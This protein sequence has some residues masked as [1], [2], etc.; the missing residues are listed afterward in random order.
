[1]K[2]EE[3]IKQHLYTDKGR[4]VS[5]GIQQDFGPYAVC[6]CDFFIEAINAQVLPRS[7]IFITTTGILGLIRL[8]TRR[9]KGS[10]IT[11]R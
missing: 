4:S 7:L 6:Q 9:G 3:L 2:L 5:S 11:V 8:K 10:G 1:M